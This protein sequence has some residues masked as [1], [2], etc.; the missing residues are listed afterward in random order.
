MTN[1]IVT[2]RKS[3]NVSKNIGNP[4]YEGDIITFVTKLI[5]L[6][7]CDTADEREPWPPH[8]LSF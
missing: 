1:L 4:V 7:S 2:L 6:L 5:T 3:A 8:F